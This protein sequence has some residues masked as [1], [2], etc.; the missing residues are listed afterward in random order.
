[1][2]V[3]GIDEINARFK[4]ATQRIRAG[5]ERAVTKLLIAI[6]GQSMFLT[7]VDTSNLIN[8][9]GR[10][11][12]PLGDHYTGYVYYGAEYAKWVHDMPGTLMGEPRADFGTTRDGTA[13]GGGTGKGNYWDPHG[14]PEFLRKAGERVAREDAPRI[15]REEMGL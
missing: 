4:L 8:S 12:Q 14:E 3:T 13:F 6:E 1:M 10:Q 11:V 7:P 15:V 5:G 2:N 9:I